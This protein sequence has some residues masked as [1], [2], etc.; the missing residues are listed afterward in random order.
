MCSFI[1]Q[2]AAIYLFIYLFIY[3]LCFKMGT[4]YVAKA[5]FQLL[6][7]NDTLTST[8]R[9]AWTTDVLF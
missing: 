3:L 4:C 1:T 8:S 7:S 5:E 6:A 2:K 9:V